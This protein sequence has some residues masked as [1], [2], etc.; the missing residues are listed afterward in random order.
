VTGCGLA[1]IKLRR[2]AQLQL[3]QETKLFIRSVYQGTSEV[4]PASKIIA[5]AFY[6]I[7][8][9]SGHGP[10]PINRRYGSIRQAGKSSHLGSTWL[11]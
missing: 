7:G 5:N 2:L 3:P 9:L 4:N 11:M 6:I 10:S 1:D 8:G